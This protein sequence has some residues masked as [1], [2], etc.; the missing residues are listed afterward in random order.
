VG[1]IEPNPQ[2]FVAQIRYDERSPGPGE[3]IFVSLDDGHTWKFVLDTLGWDSGLRPGSGGLV[4]PVLGTASV[5]PR[6]PSLLV[7]SD[8]RLT[9]DGG[10]TW[11]GDSG[12]DPKSS[13][14]MTAAGWFAATSSGV[15]R[16]QPGRE[17]VN[18]PESWQVLATGLDRPAAVAVAPDGS[19]LV[20]DRAR[21][22]RYSPAGELLGEWPEGQTTAVDGLAQDGQGQIYVAERSAHVRVISPDGSASTLMDLSGR[23]AGGVV[24]D[25]AG[26]VY[27]T[28]RADAFP[29]NNPSQAV[30]VASASDG[31]VVAQWGPAGKDPGEFSPLAWGISLDPN[32]NLYVA[33]VGNDRIQELA[34]DGSLLA[35]WTGLHA[36]AGLALDK[37]GNLY[38]ADSFADRVVELAPDGTQLASWGVWGS[39]LGQLRQPLGVAVDQ[40]SGAVYVADTLNNRLVRIEPA[41]AA[42][43]RP[44]TQ[45]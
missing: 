43:A 18:L 38:V 17:S 45:H 29:R 42:G 33:D 31:S 3:A 13:L 34:P 27:V 6:N 36:P 19:I 30:V 39:A 5:D 16:L 25:G 2:V 35:T 23:Y 7:L 24:V 20:G 8:G 26:N 15:V 28:Q 40:D 22:R 32:G 11:T 21:I 44:V 1:G 9:D 4:P 12:L 41:P 37:A 14:V 10:T